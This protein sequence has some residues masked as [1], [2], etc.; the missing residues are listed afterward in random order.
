MKGLIRLKIFISCRPD[1]RGDVRACVYLRLVLTDKGF[2]NF[3]HKGYITAGPHNQF[4]DL[5]LLIKRFVKGS[6]V[7]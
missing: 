3:C 2:S 6:K 7:T 5:S 1:G 4:Y